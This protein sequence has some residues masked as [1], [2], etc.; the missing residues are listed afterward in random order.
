MT[1][2]I[3]FPNGLNAFRKDLLQKPE[4]LNLL[5]KEI[6]V[7]CGKTMQIKFEDA[8]G[9]KV[10]EKQNTRQEPKALEP[11][12]GPDD[13]LESLDIPINFVEEE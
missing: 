6:S 9:S 8:S 4:N 2:A 10:V 5:T 13:I 7:L 1:V 12:E 11:K 3:R